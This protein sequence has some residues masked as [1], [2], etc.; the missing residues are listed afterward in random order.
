MLE[1]LSVNVGTDSRYKVCDRTLGL[2]G[3]LGDI[4]PKADRRLK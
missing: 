3:S 1:L 2:K 4:Y